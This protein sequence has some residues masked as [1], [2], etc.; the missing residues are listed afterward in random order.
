[1]GDDPCSMIPRG[2]I[3][4][5]CTKRVCDCL[6][7]SN[8]TLRARKHSCSDDNSLSTLIAAN[9]AILHRTQR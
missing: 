5:E 6:A 2:T 4:S 3:D 7:A 8:K 1:M 9:Y